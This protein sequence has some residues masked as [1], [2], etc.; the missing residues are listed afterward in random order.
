M[1]HPTVQTSPVKNVLTI[2]QPPDLI[3]SLKLIQT[4][5]TTLRQVTTTT[6]PSN[7][8]LELDDRQDFPDKGS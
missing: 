5:S 7:Q 8:I 6:I 4:N 2:L 1:I 3:L